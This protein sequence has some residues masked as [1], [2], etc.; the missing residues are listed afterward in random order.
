LENSPVQLPEVTRLI[1]DYVHFKKEIFIYASIVLSML[2][3]SF[4]TLHYRR[5]DLQF[6]DN[7]W[8]S[9][10]RIFKNT[11]NLLLE[12]ETIYIATD[13]KPDVFKDEF[14]SVFS[15][16]YNILMLDNYM[17]KIQGIPKEWVPLV[18]M[19]I[20]S[21]GRV[22]IGTRQSTFSGYVTRLRGYMNNVLNKDYYWT[23]K[24]F[25]TDYVNLVDPWKGWEREYPEGWKSIV[26]EDDPNY[27]YD[28]NN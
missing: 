6:D 12:N 1:R 4:S 11:E 15:A 7:R 8:I 18:E 24:V 9:P 27:K 20:L 22:F 14:L 5:D 21:Q 17:S 2:P 26:N 28:F 16:R 10:A 13:E 25:P 19:V 23:I 3:K